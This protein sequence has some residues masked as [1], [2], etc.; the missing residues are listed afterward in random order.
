MA[1]CILAL[2]WSRI[3]ER[4]ITSSPDRSRILIMAD[5]GDIIRALLP[6]FTMNHIT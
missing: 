1:D 5:S 3:D 2:A 4:D 6:R